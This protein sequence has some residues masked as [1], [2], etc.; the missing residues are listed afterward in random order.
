M[1]PRHADAQPQATACQRVCVHIRRAR[2][3]WALARVAVGPL[4]AEPEGGRRKRVA[5]K[6][7]AQYCCRV[8]EFIIYIVQKVDLTSIGN[9]YPLDI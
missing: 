7:G 3:D 4:G 2:G 5:R 6:K 9:T 8:L 1:T